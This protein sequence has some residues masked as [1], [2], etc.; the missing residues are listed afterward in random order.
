MAK[1]LPADGGNARRM[2]SIPGLKRSCGEGNGSALWYSCS[3][4]WMDRGAWRDAV[5]GVAKRWTQLSTQNCP[6]VY[7]FALCSTQC[8]ARKAFLINIY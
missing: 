2:G 8:H 1:N 3:G 4:N 6:E 5:H 7:L